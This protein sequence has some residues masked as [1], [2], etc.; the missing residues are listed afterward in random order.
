MSGSI[1]EC[2]KEIIA[3][4]MISNAVCSFSDVK[5]VLNSSTRTS[6]A[7]FQFQVNIGLLQSY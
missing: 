1:I 6:S 3:K 4:L 7:L 2:V 5:S